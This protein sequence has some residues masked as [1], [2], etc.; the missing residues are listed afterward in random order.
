M[1]PNN[2]RYQ[3]TFASWD[4]SVRLVEKFTEFCSIIWRVVTSRL[5]F[6]P[7]LVF[8]NSRYACC[9]CVSGEYNSWTIVAFVLSSATIRFREMVE[10]PSFDKQES[11]WIGS[12]ITR[13]FGMWT[14]IP[15]LNAA[16][17]NA[18]Y[19][20]SLEFEDLIV[21]SINSWC[22]FSAVSYTYL[23]LPTTPYV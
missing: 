13:F 15:E 20:S 19:L 2:P 17:F 3:L 11:K 4:K 7:T 22:C 8:N 1:V 23:T 21:F 6:D 18:V 9:V 14:K 10:I 5:L 16:L 12:S